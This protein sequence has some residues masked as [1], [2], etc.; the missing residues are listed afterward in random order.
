MSLRL[1]GYR[2]YLTDYTH[3]AWVVEVFGLKLVTHHPV[4]EPVSEI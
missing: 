2:E 1:R 4:I 3:R